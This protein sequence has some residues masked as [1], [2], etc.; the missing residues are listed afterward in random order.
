MR[1]RWNGTRGGAPSRRGPRRSRD[2]L[3]RRPPSHPRA[4]PTA[5]STGTSTV[6][7]VSKG[8][9]SLVA[10]RVPSRLAL[11][12][13]RGRK[14]RRPPS[15]RRSGRRRPPRAAPPRR[16]P[17]TSCSRARTS[18]GSTTTTGLPGISG[19]VPARRGLSG[20]LPHLR[21][22]QRPGRRAR[23]RRGDA[24]GRAEANGAG[25]QNPLVPA[26]RALLDSLL[27]VD[28]P[29]LSS[30]TATTRYSALAATACDSPMTDGA[31]HRSIG[32]L[33]QTAITAQLASDRDQGDPVPPSA[34]RPSVTRQRASAP[35]VSP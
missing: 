26:M 7:V 25:R 14:A 19:R 2:R 3:P 24:C 8:D 5:C 10:L 9:Q 4:W 16:A 33:T 20:H 30:A 6:L 12:A 13:N 32:S 22:A 17:T 28:E 29:V 23:G 27:P 18:G 31:E 11:P 21:L 15:R 1:L 34:G 35:Y